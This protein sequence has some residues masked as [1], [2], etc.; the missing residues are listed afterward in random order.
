MGEPG[1]RPTSGSVQLGQSSCPVP[2]VGDDTHTKTTSPLT[3]SSRTMEQ[4][5][6]CDRPIH[7]REDQLLLHDL[8][9]P[10]G[11]ADSSTEHDLLRVVGPDAS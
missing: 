7:T 10:A 8:D 5:A 9:I 6:L 3:G 1:P 2:A 4:I 11:P